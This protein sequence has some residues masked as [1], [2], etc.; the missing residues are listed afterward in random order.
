MRTLPASEAQRGIRQVVHEEYGFGGL[1]LDCMRIDRK[2]V[3]CYIDFR[4]SKG[5]KAC[6]YGSAR[7][8]GETDNMRVHGYVEKCKKMKEEK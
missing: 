2:Q 5:V 6:G 7:L 1:R 8:I 3:D 4:D